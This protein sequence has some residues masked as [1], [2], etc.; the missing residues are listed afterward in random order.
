MQTI[1][2]RDVEHLANLASDEHGAHIFIQLNG[3]IR[4]SK[5]VR[6]TGKRFFIFH[7]S[8]GSEQRLFPN[9]LNEAGL[10]LEAIATGNC[11]AEQI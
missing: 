9:D 2:I 6:F 7:E 3:W 4:S 8:D 11:F 5:W 1:P 10:M